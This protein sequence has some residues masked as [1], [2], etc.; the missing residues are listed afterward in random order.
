MIKKS[1]RFAM[2]RV[3][4]RLA[5]GANALLTNKRPIVTDGNASF[6]CVPAA[7]VHVTIAAAQAGKRTGNQ[8]VHTLRI[9]NQMKKRARNH[10][11]SSPK[12]FV[13]IIEPI[14]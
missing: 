12:L 1:A 14:P 5:A 7:V 10:D 6:V 4:I 11:I 3:L 13:S 2:A 8:A 9:M